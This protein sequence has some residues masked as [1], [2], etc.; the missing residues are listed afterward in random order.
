MKME[1]QSPWVK[2]S[3]KV[4]LCRI[5]DNYNKLV[6]EKKMRKMKTPMI[7]MSWK[8]MMMRKNKNRLMI[9]T[10][11]NRKISNHRD[12]SCSRIQIL[13]RLSKINH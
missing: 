6:R 12:K 4:K 10:V 8:K 1:D 2:I 9:R 3:K 5:I 11:V 7:M 13:K